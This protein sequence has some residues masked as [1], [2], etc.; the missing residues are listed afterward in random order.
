MLI[1]RI[2]ACMQSVFD[3]HSSRPSADYDSWFNNIM[4]YFVWQRNAG[5]IQCGNKNRANNVK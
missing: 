3:A 1:T 2:A 5:L 4:V